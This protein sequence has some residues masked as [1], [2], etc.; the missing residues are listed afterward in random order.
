MS[1]F[2]LES[3]IGPRTGTDAIIAK[4]VERALAGEFVIV[5][6]PEWSL[7]HDQR[8]VWSVKPSEAPYPH[9][10]STVEEAADAMVRGW[11]RGPKNG[12]WR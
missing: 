3:I 5:G 7:H 4:A 11:I 2:Y 9:F 8:R 1:R 6:R 12:S 10:Y